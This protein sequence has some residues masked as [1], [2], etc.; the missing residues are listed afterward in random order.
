VPKYGDRA[1]AGL[2]GRDSHGGYDRPL[3]TTGREALSSDPAHQS[4]SG[5]RGQAKLAVAALRR[6]CPIWIKLTANRQTS[7][8]SVNVQ[9]GSSRARRDDGGFIAFDPARQNHND[10]TGPTISRPEGKQCRRYG[11]ARERHPSRDCGIQDYIAAQGWLEAVHSSTA[12]AQRRGARPDVF[13]VEPTRKIPLR[14]PA[15]P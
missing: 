1:W 15:F 14:H 3:E 10:F 6:P 12:I 5:R 4:P 8:S 7:S 13:C 11:A 2:S 9:V